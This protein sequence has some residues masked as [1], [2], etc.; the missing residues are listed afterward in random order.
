MQIVVTIPDDETDP[1]FGAWSA[2]VRLADELP[3]RWDGNPDGVHRYLR[4]DDG[5]DD[6]AHEW[7]V[8]K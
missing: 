5:R 7:W 4:N 2:L 6:H 1:H 3:R 8:A